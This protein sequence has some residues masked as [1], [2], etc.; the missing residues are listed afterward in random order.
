MFIFKIFKS[1]PTVFSEQ[2]QFIHSEPVLYDLPKNTSKNSH[3]FTHT[4][5]RAR[6]KG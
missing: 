4:F 1:S 2:E 3:W 5:M 6:R